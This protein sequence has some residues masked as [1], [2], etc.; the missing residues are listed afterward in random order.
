MERVSGDKSCDSLKP[1]FE[2]RDDAERRHPP[3]RFE[4]DTLRDNDSSKRRRI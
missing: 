1:W 3:I 2:G 4:P